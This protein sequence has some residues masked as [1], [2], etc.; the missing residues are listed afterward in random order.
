MVLFS[1]AGLSSGLIL[2]VEFAH[3]YSSPIAPD[4]N[5]IYT[6]KKMATTAI[7]TLQGT[8]LVSIHEG[9]MQFEAGAF[10]MFGD[11]I[12]TS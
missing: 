2:L 12:F 6:L 3:L 7:L 8:I 11:E 9:K 4:K 10:M 5:I 1:S